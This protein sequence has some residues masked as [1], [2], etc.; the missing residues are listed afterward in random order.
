MAWQKCPV[1]NGT[2]K[3]NEFYSKRNEPCPT[4]NGQRIINEATGLAPSIVNI[5]SSS[6]TNLPIEDDNSKQ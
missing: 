4:C 1:C 5:K 2:G 6:T 3:N